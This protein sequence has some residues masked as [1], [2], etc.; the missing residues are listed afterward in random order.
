VSNGYLPKGKEKSNLHFNYLRTEV[1]IPVTAFCD[2]A[3]SRIVGNSK[4]RQWAVRPVY[5]EMVVKGSRHG[6]PVCPET[7]VKRLIIDCSDVG[8]GVVG[9]GIFHVCIFSSI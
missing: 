9:V 5:R 1:F 2:I 8:L 7:V 3:H 6:S 4:D